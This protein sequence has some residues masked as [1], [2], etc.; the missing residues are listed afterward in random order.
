[1]TSKTRPE[2]GDHDEQFAAPQEAQGVIENLQKEDHTKLMLIARGFTRTRLKGT[3]VEPD[4][5]VHDAIAKTLD[6]RRRW[7]RKVT[8]IKHLDRVMESDSGHVA[9]QRTREVDQLPDVHAEPVAQQPSPEAR[10]QARETLDNGLALFSE[11]K[12]ALQ[13]IRLKSD[14]FSVSEIQ[15]ELDM[16]KTQYETVSKR[17]RRRFAK[18]LAE[19]GK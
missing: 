7:N 8:I 14:G 2:P 13:L 16:R 5:L 10:L 3:V 1:M 12:I 6:G 18:H 4:D 15:R 19:G 11:D 17:I 9:E